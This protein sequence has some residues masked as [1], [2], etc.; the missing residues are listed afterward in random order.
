MAATPLGE[1]LATLPQ[2][3]RLEWIGLRP[4]RGAPVQMVAEA[5]L[6]PGQ[7]LCGD[8]FAAR[9]ADNPRQVTLIQHEHLAAIAS[10]A[11]LD[12]V[13][14]E[15]LRRNLVVAGINLLALKDKRFRIGAAL[16]EYGGP[17]HPCS[18][19]ERALGAGGYNAMRG[20]GGII[21]RVVA[22]APIRI[23]DPVT[24]VP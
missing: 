13:E 6:I 17:C 24:V 3:G 21:A 4:A 10:L 7:G 8:R 20:H 9:S 16:L 23:G 11:G 1:L 19:M 18:R 22:G 14:P 12:M 5:E 2:T 15:L